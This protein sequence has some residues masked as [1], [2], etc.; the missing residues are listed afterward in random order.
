[1]LNIFLNVAAFHAIYVHV[2][3]NDRTDI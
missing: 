3:L 1:M 2:D